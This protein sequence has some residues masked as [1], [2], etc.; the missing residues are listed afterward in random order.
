MNE[1][2]YMEEGWNDTDNV[3]GRKPE[4]LAIFHHRFH[5]NWPKIEIEISR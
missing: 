1:V 4:P 5:M 3:L 2:M